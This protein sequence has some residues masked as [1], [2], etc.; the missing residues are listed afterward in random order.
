MLQLLDRSMSFRSASPVV[1]NLPLRVR[2]AG[3]HRVGQEWEGEKPRQKWFVELFW[4][5]EGCGEFFDGKHWVGLKPGE[6]F[7]YRPGEVHRLRATSPVWHYYWVTLDHEESSRWVDGFGLT[8]RKHQ[9]GKCPVEYFEKIGRALRDGTAEGERQAAQLVHALLM[10]AATTTGQAL[11]GSLA[12]RAMAVMNQS[13]ADP[14]FSVAE[15]SERMGIHRSTLFRQFIAVHGL[16]P[17]TYLHNLR[18]QRGLGLLR[19]KQIPIHEVAEAAGFSDAN[20][21]ARVIREVTGMS[22]REFRG[23]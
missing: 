13:F 15:L 20:Y 19:E 4:G 6:V 10:E 8:G 17:S 9:A 2:S 3:W 5:E 12:M 7:I 21:F 18:V 11:P 16:K 1:P 14:G 22:P 23:Q